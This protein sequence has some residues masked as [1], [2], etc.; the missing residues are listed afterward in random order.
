M[1][2]GRHVMFGV[3]AVVVVS[4]SIGG[5]TAEYCVM[6]WWEMVES[7]EMQRSEGEL[8]KAVADWCRGWHNAVADDDESMKMGWQVNREARY[9]GQ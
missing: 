1:E 7:K 9:E 8:V 5:N 2:F 4:R 6:Y 3:V